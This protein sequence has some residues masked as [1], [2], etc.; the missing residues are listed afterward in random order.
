M[1][2]AIV[3]ADTPAGAR[4]IY[5]WAAGNSNGE[6]NLDGSVVSATSV[7][8]TAGLPLR[9]PELRGHSLAVV[10]T[11]RR[12]DRGVLQP[13]RDCEGVLPG[14][15]GG[16]TSLDPCRAS[17]APTALRSAISHWNSPGR[18]RPHRSSPAGSG[19]SRSTTATRLG[20]DEIVERML[21]TADSTGEYADS[22][23]YGRGFLDST[24]RPVRWA[25]RG[26]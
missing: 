11:D 5:V 24:P 4:T 1:I 23:V 19:C 9:I 10:A 13:L 14:R 7:D 15:S 16:W 3:Q 8:I 17:T 6:V 22:D 20:S 25:G 12:A 18:R 2:D 21:A 26:C